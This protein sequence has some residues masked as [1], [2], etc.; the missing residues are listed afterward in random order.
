MRKSSALLAAIAAVGFVYPAL[1]DTRFWHGDA[2]GAWENVLNWDDDSTLPLPADTIVFAGAPNQAI[3]TGAPREAA[4]LMFS[5]ATEYV[6]NSNTLTLGGVSLMGTGPVTMN[7]GLVASSVIPVNGLGANLLTLN[8]VVANGTANGG[9]NVTN[10][11]VVLANTVNSYSGGTT[12]GVGGYVQLLGSGAAPQQVVVGATGNSLIGAGAITIDGGTLKLSTKGFDAT[13]DFNNGTNGINFSR[14]ISFGANGGF[15]DITSATGDPSLGYAGHI[16]GGTIPINTTDGATSPVIFRFDGGNHGLSRLGG[17]GTTLNHPDWAS[18]GNTLRF[19]AITGSGPI[20]VELSNGALHRLGDGAAGTQAV[21]NAYTVRGVAGGD[22]TSG[23]DGL[24]NSGIS[25]TTARIG[26]DGRAQIDFN[27]GLFLQDAIQVGAMG[28]T[29]AINGNIT[30]AGIDSGHPATVAFSGRGTGTNFSAGAPNA[31]GTGS[32]G[33]NV[34]WLGRDGDDVMTVENGAA[35][36]LDLRIRQDQSFHHAVLLN[37]KTVLHAGGKLGFRQSLSNSSVL[38]NPN[39]EGT[40]LPTVASVGN[41]IVQG[42][43]QAQGTTANESVVDLYIPFDNT[44]GTTTAGNHPLGGVV[45][46]NTADLIINGSGYGGLRVNGLA[47]PSNLF[48]G[49]GADPV[50]N[51]DKVANLLSPARLAALTGTGGFLTP[52]PVDKPFT[53]LPGSEWAPQVPVGLKVINSNTNPAESGGADVILGTDWGHDVL[54]EAGATLGAAGQTLTGTVF[55][56][57]SIVGPVQFGAG[58]ELSP[59]LS[60][61]KLTIDG[62]L[63]LAETA[64]YRVELLGLVPGAEYDQIDLLGGL[65]LGADSQ[66]LASLGFDPAFGDSFTIVNNESEGGIDGYFSGLPQGAIFSLANPNTGNAFPFQISYVGGTGNDVVLTVAVP[67]P[68]TA[69]LLAIGTMMSLLRVRRRK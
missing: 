29:R 41:H 28:S 68:A 30:L 59:G 60:P 12:I 66:L 47:R 10:A 42:D 34:M 15:V 45:F 1:A 57:G 31:P 51:A 32:A 24:V 35:A 69:G 5:S 62:A 43:I 2:D 61:G 63:S 50:S 56:S 67:E 7:S 8:G 65:T 13:A 27:G 22:P 64:A 49:G 17:T 58:G 44:F 33:H 37:A 46:E 18:G 39:A 25:R 16:T 21:A 3:E 26:I 20:Q 11:K 40:I 52:A 14:A 19:G 36:I 6:L 38:P 54:V 48:G 53:V 23:A 55:G 4:L 9:L